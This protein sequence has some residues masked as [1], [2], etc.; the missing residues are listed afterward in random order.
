MHRRYM[1]IICSVLQSKKTIYFV[2]RSKSNYVEISIRTILKS[3]AL[4]FARALNVK[5]HKSV[6]EN[7]RERL[8]ESR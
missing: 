3:Y 2:V 4:R 6:S 5:E 8:S 1:Y 7:E